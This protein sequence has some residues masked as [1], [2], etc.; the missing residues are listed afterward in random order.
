MPAEVPSKVMLSTPAAST[1][2][3]RSRNSDSGVKSNV[4]VGEAEATS[5]VEDELEVL[6]QAGPGEV[7]PDPF[8]L[9][10]GEPAERP[11]ERRSLTYRV[12]GDV[13][14]V[15][16]GGYNGRPAYSSFDLQPVKPCPLIATKR[17]MRGLGSS[18]PF[19]AT[20]PRSENS[21]GLPA[22]ACRTT[23]ETRMP[24]SSA[25]DSKRF[26]MTTE[27]PC[28]SPSSSMGSPA[29][30][31]MRRRM[32]TSL[33]ANFSETPPLGRNGCFDCGAGDR[34]FG[35]ESVA[36]CLDDAATVLGHSGFENGVVVAHDLAH[37]LVFE[38]GKERR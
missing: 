29:L 2:A 18:K 13:D 8:L 35:H 20:S 21:N 32:G 19:N 28:R 16:G 23:S 15:L 10:V 36:D 3:S 12:V 4:A 38:L 11:D 30:T 9:D 6:G 33:S 7:S 17:P 37:L 27:A 14:P 24:P 34:E 26:A 22:T 31:P 25:S 5:V 1:T